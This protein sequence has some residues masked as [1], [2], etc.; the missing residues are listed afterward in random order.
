M[1]LFLDRH[2]CTYKQSFSSTSR[3]EPCNVIPYSTP[4]IVLV[5]RE[6]LQSDSFSHENG[7]NYFI[8]VFQN[9]QY[10]P[11]NLFPYSTPCTIL[12]HR[13]FLQSDFFDQ[14]NRRNYFFFCFS[15]LYSYMFV[16][17]GNRAEN[18]LAISIKARKDTGLH[19]THYYTI[20]FYCHI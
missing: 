2:T 14:K 1:Q 16:K 17:G 4:R 8:S 18:T 6:F 20:R 10:A 11:C 9:K 12:V 3:Y 7:R 19:I 15:S 5:N 13:D